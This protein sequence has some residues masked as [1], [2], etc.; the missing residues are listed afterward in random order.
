M[1]ALCF[2]HLV[3]LLRIFK[4][5]KGHG[6]V[7]VGA[8]GLSGMSEVINA[9]PSNTQ[10]N[11]KPNLMKNNSK[12][13]DLCVCMICV[14]LCVHLWCAYMYDMCVYVCMICM[15][16]YSVCV[17]IYIY[18]YMIYVCVRLWLSV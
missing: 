12:S 1:Q 5:T 8:Q 7:G 14:C 16:V 4:S 9:M 6:I 17:Y 3:G 13:E 2:E 15:C 10:H 11:T 18:I